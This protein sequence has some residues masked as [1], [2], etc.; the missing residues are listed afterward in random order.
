MSFKI[1][2]NH[3]FKVRPHWTPKAPNLM[4]DHWLSQKCF[5]APNAARWARPK[6]IFPHYLSFSPQTWLRS[7][8]S[9]HWICGGSSR[10]VGN[11]NAVLFGCLIKL[12]SGP[13]NQARP[14]PGPC[15]FCPSP[16][17]PDTCRAYL[18]ARAQFQPNIFFNT[19]VTLYTFVT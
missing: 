8:P 18:W 6:L 9:L 2:Q 1:Y 16:A 11:P 5:N 7:P 4:L 13:E 10:G 19:C 14:S 15:T 12:R 17:R 3:S